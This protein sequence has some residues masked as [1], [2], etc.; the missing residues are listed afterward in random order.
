MNKD[1]FLKLI[2]APII[3]GIIVYILTNSPLFKN[4]G[5]SKQVD[6][7]P[8]ESPIIDS[9]SVLTTTYNLHLLYG[10]NF[11]TNNAYEGKVSENDKLLNNWRIYP[12][13]GPSFYWRRNSNGFS[14]A[15]WY[16]ENKD[17]PGDDYQLVADNSLINGIP[18][19]CGFSIEYSYDDKGIF[20]QDLS[21]DI[22]FFISYTEYDG[23]GG[24]TQHNLTSLGTLLLSQVSDDTL[25]IYINS[26][27]II[28]YHN[29]VLDYSDKFNEYNKYPRGELT[30]AISSIGVCVKNFKYYVK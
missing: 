17:K 7:A 30:V 29:N 21:P 4:W 3:V 14:F 20:V 13:P 16:N 25:Q 8:I 1:T 5:S 28:Y 6:S 27:N 23:N 24:I 18:N 26:N 10:E 12:Q 11:S 22:C 2:I 15:N 19:E 9:P